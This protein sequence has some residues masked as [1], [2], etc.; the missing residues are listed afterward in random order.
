MPLLTLLTVLTLASAQD[1]TRR[2][3]ETG[4]SAWSGSATLTTSFVSGPVNPGTTTRTLTGVETWGSTWNPALDVGLSAAVSWRARPEGVLSLSW[5]MR[6]V[7]RFD[8]TDD[9][10]PDGVGDGAREAPLETGDLVLSFRDDAV[11]ATED[12][13]V[14]LLLGGRLTLPASRESLVCNPLVGALGVS[15]GTRV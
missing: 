1:P 4:G 7:F 6:R 15:V 13:R 12:G 3:A 8:D 5:S 14:G 11:V 2:A 9:D 10:V